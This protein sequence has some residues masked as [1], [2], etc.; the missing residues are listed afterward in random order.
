[1]RK[2]ECLKNVGKATL[3]DLTLLDIQNVE[4]LARQDPTF[5]FHELEKR[6]RHRQDPC[7]WDIFASII[8]EAATGEPSNWWEWT[9]KRK[10]L[11]KQG[12][13]HHAL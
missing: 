3:S 11:E 2:L 1:M 12:L 10:A 6:T 5:L 13:F 7:L 9:K 4:E 8:H